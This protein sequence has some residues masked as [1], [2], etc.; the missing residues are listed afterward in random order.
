MTMILPKEMYTI[1][2]VFLFV[3]DLCCSMMG[4]LLHLH[5]GD[6]GVSHGN[7]KKQISEE[8]ELPM[9]QFKIS[10]RGRKMQFKVLVDTQM[11]TTFMTSHGQRNKSIFLKS[12]IWKE[13]FSSQNVH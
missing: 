4:K 6:E 10:F 13:Q 12:F 9:G 2:S 8:C 7:R 11:V 5:F 1:H 3:V